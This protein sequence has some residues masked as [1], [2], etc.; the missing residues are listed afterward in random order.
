M[1]INRLDIKAYGHFT[2]FPIDLSSELPGLHIIFG[3]NEAGKSTALRALRGLLYGIDARTPDNFL[4]DYSKLLIGG[5]L[6]NSKGDSL[7][8][9]RR[10]RNVGDLL[11]ADMA[12][13]DAGTLNDFLVGVGEPLFDSLFG[14]NHETLISGGQDILEQKGDV[15][16]ALFSA[17]AGLSSLHGIIEALDEE[18]ADLFKAGGSKPE[19]NST[20]KHFQ[21]LN[22]EIRDL[23]LSSSTW[24]QQEELFEKA[25]AQLIEAERERIH[26]RAEME[27]LKRLQRAIPYLTRRRDMLEN[28]SLLGSMDHLPRNFLVSLSEIRSDIEEFGKKISVAESLKE[29]LAAKIADCTVQQE[30]LDQAEMVEALYQRLGAQLQAKKDRPVNNEKMISASTKASTLLNQVI[31]GF[32]LSEISEIKPFI[33]RRQDILKLGNQYAGLK[34]T[35]QQ[36]EK[37]VKELGSSLEQ[38]QK[39]LN[40]IPEYIEISGLASA[41]KSSRKAGNMDQYIRDLDLEI[42]TN[43]SSA[44]TEAKQLVPWK[45]Q[46]DDLLSLPIPS[47]ETVNKF[48]DDIRNAFDAIR[49]IEK[50][51]RQDQGEL[52]RIK[53]DLREMEKSG[54]VPTEEEL[55]QVRGGREKGWQLIRRTWLEKQDISGEIKSLGADKGLPEFYEDSVR[56]ADEVADRLRIEAERVHKY[57][58]LSAQAEKFE[59]KI[60]QSM[61]FR[62]KTDK[63]LKQ[64]EKSWQEVWRDCGLKPLTPGEMRGWLERCQDVRRILKNQLDKAEQKKNLVDQRQGLLDLLKSE[65]KGIGKVKKFQGDDVEPISTHAEQLLEELKENNNKRTALEKEIE[66]AHRD[67]EPAKK[68]LKTNQ[69]TLEKWQEQWKELMKGIRLSKD[70]SPEHA[71]EV[72]ETLSACLKQIREAD[73]FKQRLD[74]MEEY[75]KV[76][77]SDVQALVESV[78]TEIKYLPPEQAV[79]KLQSMLKETR[80]QSTKRDGFI[81]RVEAAE[82]DLRLAKVEHER[83]IERID[84]L[85]K[86]ARCKDD[87]QLEEVEKN[88]REYGDLSDKLIQVEETLAGIAEGVFLEELDKQRQD[89]DPNNLPGD[90]ETLERRL[91]DELDPLIKKLSED[92]GEART[93]LQQ[94]DGSGKAA[95]KE[96]EAQQALTKL[97]RL[98]DNYVRLRIAALVLKREVDHYRQ[99]NQDPILKIAARYFSELTMGAYSGLRADIDDSGKPILVGVCPDDSFKIV[100]EMSSGTRDQLYL[101]LRLATLEWRLEKHEPMPFIA[102]DILVNFDDARAK[103]TLKALATLAVKN[104]VILFTHHAQIL[105]TAKALGLNDRVFVH[106][107]NTT[108]IEAN[109]GAELS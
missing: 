27:R 102:D 107:L 21:T 46:I 91:K 19:I 76:F 95:E 50:S 89:I 18:G 68:E 36:T 74:A 67:I 77:A 33:D 13:L 70:T 39:D 99:E 82:E 37:R 7:V 78:A 90:I 32:E 103:A 6:K 83:A 25:S 48:A 105:G 64:I 22:K 10:K 45:G 8:F 41:I 62:E 80:D 94:M 23:S 47:L 42:K 52:G 59:E 1:R 56:T 98:A 104:Q 87:E 20:T 101:S 106:S 12:L 65:L 58:N 108:S 2:D 61:K 43:R 9:W 17:G 69:S 16:Q 35:L 34:A 109:S 100:Q 96:E 29:S 60:Q 71:V 55:S 57:A 86:A 31:P 75:A 38:A 30:L 24:K 15:G 26:C 63:Q 54:A 72:L 49:D 81:E 40:A 5:H 88:Y 73:G 92:K 85:R 3:P 79:V 93:I 97:R 11:D 28:L 84:E 51:M 66:A 4:H 14:I 44:E 53:S